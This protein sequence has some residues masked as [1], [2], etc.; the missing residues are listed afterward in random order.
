MSHI[1]R[2]DLGRRIGESHPNAILTDHDV[3]LVLALAEAG[4]SYR[5]IAW[6]FEVSKTCIAKI[7]SGRRRGQWDATM[8]K[9]SVTMDRGD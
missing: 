5:E 4:L 2:N 3:E 7:C 6:K 8:I 9:V 1:R